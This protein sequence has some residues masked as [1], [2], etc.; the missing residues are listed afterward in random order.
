MDH[1]T[2]VCA[3]SRTAKLRCMYMEQ[4]ETIKW[5]IRAERTGDW[6]LHLV[7]VDRMLNPFAATCH[8]N[9]E[10]SGRLYLHMMMELPHTHTWLYEQFS[11]N[12]FF[13]C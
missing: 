6:N 12:G 3:L 10:K 9:Y 4:I 8:N 5:F 13:Y 1:K 2:K 11:S 7:A